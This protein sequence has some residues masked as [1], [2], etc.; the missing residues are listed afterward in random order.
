MKGIGASPGIAIG[1]V[2]VKKSQEHKIEK[3]PIVGIKEEVEKFKT[4]VEASKKEIE[5]LYTHTF[6]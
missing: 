3:K 5:E 6:F 1:K 4:A 2:P